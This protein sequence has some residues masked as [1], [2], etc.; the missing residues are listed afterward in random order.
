MSQFEF[1]MVMVSLI[2]ALALAQAL[3]GLCEVV[4]SQNRYWPLTPWLAIYVLQITQVWWAYWDFNAVDR[5]RF[6]TYIM[7]LTPP[8]IIFAAIYLLV[9]ATRSFEFDWCQQ[10]HKVRQFFFGLGI[11]LVLAGIFVNVEYFGTPL[12]HPYR[13]VQGSAFAIF[14]AGL[15]TSSATVHRVLP[16]LFLIVMVTSQFLLRLNI[17]A[18]MAE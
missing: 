8:I 5:W 14:L 16:I 18:M 9:P 10:F 12:V 17:G 7:A 1:V 3:R 6:T 15:L 2:L 13:V 4:T 11:A